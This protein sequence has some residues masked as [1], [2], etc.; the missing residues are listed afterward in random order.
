MKHREAEQLV[1]SALG[2]SM[3]TLNDIAAHL[4]L[5]PR[6]V[7]RLRAE[8]KLPEP[9]FQIAGTGKRPIVRWR[10][11]TIKRFVENSRERRR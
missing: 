9:D 1:R 4:S 2:E 5:S 6:S 11:S 7:K 8:G 10:R 3:V